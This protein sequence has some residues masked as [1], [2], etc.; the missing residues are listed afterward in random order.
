MKV[1]LDAGHGGLIEGVY[2]T[3]GKRSPVWKDGN[4]LFE[5]VFNRR[6]VEKIKHYLLLN[7]I[8][9]VDVVYSNYDVSLLKRVKKANE[10]YQKDKSCIYVSVHANA[11]PETAK[12]WEIFT[13]P[14][15]TNSDTLATKIFE[16]FAKLCPE[17]HVRIDMTDKD[18]DKEEK[19]F[20]LTQT[21]CP[22]VLVECGF[23]TNYEEC[24]KLMDPAYQDKLAES[25]VLGIKEYY[26][27]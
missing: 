15:Q 12:G 20:V 14:G 17:T 6:V 18:P 24:K 8:E 19:F 7:N 22:S 1:L 21:A 27:K 4:Q 11:G 13:S 5:G 16:Q 2:V 10:E 25:I 26:K 3:P 9:Y 23:M